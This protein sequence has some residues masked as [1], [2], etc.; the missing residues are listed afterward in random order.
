MYTIP[1]GFNLDYIISD[2][3]FG[4]VPDSFIMDDV[5]CGGSEKILWDCR[6]NKHDNCGSGEGAGIVCSDPFRKC[7]FRSIITN[8]LIWWKLLATGLEPKTT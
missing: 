4:K 7:R 3:E 8:C 1:L 6:Y 2:S 5:D